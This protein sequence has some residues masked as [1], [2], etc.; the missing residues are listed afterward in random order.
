VRATALIMQRRAAVLGV[1]FVVFGLFVVVVDVCMCQ[2]VVLSS[3]RSLK[4]RGRGKIEIF[5]VNAT[6]TAPPGHLDLP[7]SRD[8]HS[9][10]LQAALRSTFEIT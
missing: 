2:E 7:H 1:C 9:V 8:K 4:G 3:C 6:D 10:L 5:K